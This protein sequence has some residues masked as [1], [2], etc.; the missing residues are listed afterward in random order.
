MSCV[1]MGK[2]ERTRTFRKPRRKLDYNVRW[3]LKNVMAESV[4]RFVKLRLEASDECRG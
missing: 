2:P 3:V 1:L 4:P